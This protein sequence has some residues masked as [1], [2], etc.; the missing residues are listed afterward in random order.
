MR[1]GIWDRSEKV[2]PIETTEKEAPRYN[3]G[4]G[5]EGEPKCPP[6]YRGPPALVVPRGL[7]DLGV[8]HDYFSILP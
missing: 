8:D 1:R 2:K 5:S 3:R 7:R 6:I 4:H